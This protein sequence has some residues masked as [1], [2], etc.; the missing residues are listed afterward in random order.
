MP[1]KVSHMGYE[2]WC[3]ECETGSGVTD[4]IEAEKWKKDHN[5]KFHQK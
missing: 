5:Q 1:A 2:A 3:G 4:L